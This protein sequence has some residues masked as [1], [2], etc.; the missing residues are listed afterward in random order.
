MNPEGRVHDYTDLAEEDVPDLQQIATGGH[1]SEAQRQMV[2]NLQA[3]KGKG[4]M[5]VESKPNQPSNMSVS[6]VQP[7]IHG[8]ASGNKECSV[9]PFGGISSGWPAK[10]GK[11][12][13]SSYAEVFKNRRGIFEQGRLFES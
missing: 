10:N 3:C 4:K 7:T 12:F 8:P 2:E 9:E 1:N 11:T 13:Q 6:P 5:R